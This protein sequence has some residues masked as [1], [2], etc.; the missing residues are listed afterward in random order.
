MLSW[1]FCPH[2]F[3]LCLIHEVELWQKVI[4]A[5]EPFSDKKNC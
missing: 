2:C 5:A 3:I 4:A 1:V